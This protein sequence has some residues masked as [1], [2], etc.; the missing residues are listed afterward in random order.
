MTAKM[1][2][3]VTNIQAFIPILTVLP[4]YDNAPFLWIVNHPDE[5]GVGGYLCV[6]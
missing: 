5:G 1:Y 6:G 2:T 3:T 4:E